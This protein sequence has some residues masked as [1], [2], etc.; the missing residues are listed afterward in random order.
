MATCS[1]CHLCEQSSP[2]P[3][4]SPT[5]FSCERVFRKL[6]KVLEEHIYG[7]NHKQ[8]SVDTLMCEQNTRKLLPITYT[9]WWKCTILLKIGS[10]IIQ[11]S[12]KANS[13]MSPQSFITPGFGKIWV[14]LGD[15][16][17]YEFSVKE[18]SKIHKIKPNKTILQCTQCLNKTRFS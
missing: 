3:L 8:T 13:Q 6:E 15:C 10:K 5:Y 4:K 2:T 17:L 11:V 1:D 14:V 16:A 9:Q 12:S 18:K 7:Q